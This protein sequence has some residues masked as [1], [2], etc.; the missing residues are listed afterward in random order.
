[1]VYPDKRAQVPAPGAENG[2]HDRSVR[3]APTASPPP[4]TAPSHPQPAA[5]QA[6][7]AADMAALEASHRLMVTQLR[8]EKENAE[9]RAALEA[10]HHQ[11]LAQ[12]RAEKEN[13][14]AQMVAERKIHEVEMGRLKAENRAAEAE[15]RL[16]VSRGVT[17]SPITPA[18]PRLTGYS[19]ASTPMGNLP[20]SAARVVLP[21]TPA[22]PR[23]PAVATPRTPAVATP[24]PMAP[25]ANVVDDTSKVSE[26]SAL[27]DAAN[28]SLQEKLQVFLSWA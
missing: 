19:I 4:S 9:L 27:V 25:A 23:T 28:H 14:E 13:V 16:A 20:M 10:T 15:A 18:A 8:A 6:T 3:M 26:Q 21:M 24:M 5:L 12:A 22:A 7:P 17:A 11:Q 2:A 1:M